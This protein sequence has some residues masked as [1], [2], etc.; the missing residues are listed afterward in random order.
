[1][2]RLFTRTRRDASARQLTSSQSSEDR[3]SQGRKHSEIVKNNDSHRP[4]FLNPQTWHKSRSTQNL[5]NGEA[6]PELPKSSKKNGTVNTI[7]SR[8]SKSH[9]TEDEDSDEEEFWCIGEGETGKLKSDGI[10]SNKDRRLHQKSSI[11]SLGR[12][13]PKP[14]S[15]QLQPRV[16]TK[17]TRPTYKPTSSSIRSSSTDSSTAALSVAS[18][19]RSISPYTDLSAARSLLH[20]RS[21]DTVHSTRRGEKANS[22][23]GSSGYNSDVSEYRGRDVRNACRENFRGL[24][25]KYSFYSPSN[26]RQLTDK[27]INIPK[28]ILSDQ[29]PKIK[30]DQT[31]IPPR[32]QRIVLINKN[33][34]VPPKKGAKDIRRSYGQQ[35]KDWKFQ[36]K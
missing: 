10:P 17:K 9:T 12:S 27:K 7:F 14:K 11:N 13:E 23:T 19:N 34:I 35:G 16:S 8:K 22:E 28:T 20:P 5:T 31:A 3:A 36:K 32:I 4:K 6:I 33:L 18:S 25:S 26:V 1:M 2:S 15:G 30:S 21:I 29:T 24:E